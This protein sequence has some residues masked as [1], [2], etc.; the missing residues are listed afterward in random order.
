[1]KFGVPQGSVLGPKEYSM[2]TIPVGRI[3][4]RH[5]L[6]HFIYADDTQG[7]VLIESRDNW[8]LTSSRIEA[9]VGE[10]MSLNLLKLNQDKTEFIIFHS[11]HQ[12]LSPLEF[13]IKIGQCTLTPAPYVRNLG[14]I[15][16]SCLIT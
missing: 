8:P 11:L 15:Q 3:I 14:V 4:Q 9:H 6:R 2:Y 13:P 7:C 16:D 10:W 5:E 1:M 12:P